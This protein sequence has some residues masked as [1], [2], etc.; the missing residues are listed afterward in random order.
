MDPAMSATEIRRS[1][2]DVRNAHLG[3]TNDALKLVMTELACMQR[4]R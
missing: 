2:T 4:V 1:C 3:N